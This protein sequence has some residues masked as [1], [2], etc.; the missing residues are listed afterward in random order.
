MKDEKEKMED[1]V[2]EVAAGPVSLLLGQAKLLESHARAAEREAMNH[3]S[4]AIVFD[5]KAARLQVQAE[6][7]RD[8][9]QRLV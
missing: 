1:S 6:E 7:M 3:R 4:Q 5:R 9:A 8:A 2:Q